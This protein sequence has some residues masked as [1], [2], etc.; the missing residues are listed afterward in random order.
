[1]FN[2][3]YR[4]EIYKFGFV[5]DQGT[6][7][8]DGADVLNTHH[9]SQPRLAWKNNIILVHPLLD[10]ISELVDILD[11]GTVTCKQVFK[12]LIHIL[13]QQNI[14]YFLKHFQKRS[15]LKQNSF[16]LLHAL[17]L[18]LEEP[19]IQIGFV[20]LRVCHRNV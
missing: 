10:E 17:R 15:L 16:F 2:V 3:F 6:V 9:T 18:V 4:A 13:W 20:T 19:L 12:A 14:T 1:M 7:L 8:V 5:L 11:S